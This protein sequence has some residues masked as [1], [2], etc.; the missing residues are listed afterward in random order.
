MVVMLAIVAIILILAAV[1]GNYGVVAG[2]LEKDMF[3]GLLGSG[4]FQC[5]RV[6]ML[7]AASMIAGSGAAMAK[8]CGL[9]AK[10][11]AECK[12][13]ADL[14]ECRAECDARP[15]ADGG[16]FCT[17]HDVLMFRCAASRF[18]NNPNECFHKIKNF[19]SDIKIYVKASETDRDPEYK[20]AVKSSYSHYCGTKEK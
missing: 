17:E 10:P 15:S 9:N 2:Q 7:F 19:C 5:C 16:C 3:S 4:S 11:F 12:T 18:L 6:I 20:Q 8:P 14:N 13:A 1:R